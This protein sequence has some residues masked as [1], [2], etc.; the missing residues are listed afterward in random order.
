MHGSELERLRRDR[1]ELDHHI[2]KLNKKGRS[3]VAY[4]LNRKRDFLNNTIM[5]LQQ[6]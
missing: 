1:K 4:K 6:Y 2:H 5:E 3:E